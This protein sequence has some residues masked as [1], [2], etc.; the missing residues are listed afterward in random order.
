MFVFKKSGLANDGRVLREYVITNASVISVGEAVKLASG[1]LVT[2]G[3]GGE[4]LGI[5]ADI[6]KLDGSPL[7]DNG[8]GGD[9]TN[10]YTAGATEL[11]VA[12]VDVS[13]LSVYSV[14]QDA[15]LGTTT[16][17]GL[18]GYNTDCGA[19]SVDLDESSTVSTTA[20]FCIE[21]VD[22][23]PLAPDNSVLVH[24]QE[25]QFWL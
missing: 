17:S 6:R 13:K 4:G 25:S 19:G 20:S 12:V 10:T 22:P 16:G 11:A 24:I 7:T 5:V 18:A 3:V 23:D 8:A 2:W 1:K 21:G 9:F 15:A 14:A